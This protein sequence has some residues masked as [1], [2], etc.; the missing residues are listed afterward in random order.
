[1]KK[2]KHR[3][4]KI[5]TALFC[6]FFLS[7][8]MSVSVF[9][10]DGQTAIFNGSDIVGNTSVSTNDALLPGDSISTTVTITNSYSEATNWYLSSD[11]TE[12]LEAS[13]G[14]AA[15]TGYTYRLTY[16][17]PSGTET[18]LYSSENI[19]GENEDS[20][21]NAVAALSSDNAGTY[22]YL[23][24]LASGQSGKVTL[25]MALDGETTANSYQS[26]AAEL[27]LKFATEL[28]STTVPETKY[29]TLYKTGDLQI[30]Q[31]ADGEVPLAYIAPRTS[32]ETRLWLFVVI[33]G[34]CSLGLGICFAVKLSPAARK[35]RG[36]RA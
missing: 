24:T 6:A 18:A 23:G 35:G 20:L 22:Y 26:S 14:T 13:K 21:A 10:E 4:I 19:V 1:M 25:Y 9:A 34:L 12:S 31:I 2:K 15:G 17:E 33:M 11:V 32:D 36:T 27:Y 30:V 8:A 3:E 29:R 7:G 5:L 16:T 28:V